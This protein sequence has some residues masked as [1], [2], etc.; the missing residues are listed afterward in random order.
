MSQYDFGTIDPY[1]VDGVQLADMLNQW[2]DALLSMHRGAARPTY[3]VPGMM[4]INDSAGAASW[5]VNVYLGPT[6]GDTPLFNYN[7]TTGAITISAASGGT[8]AAA[9]LLAQANANPTVEWNSTQ[10]PID[11]KDWRSIITS[12]GALRFSAYNDAGTTELGA[13]QIERDGSIPTL[14]P[15]GV[16]WDFGGATAPTGWYLCDGTL[17][18]RTTDA[19]LFTAISTTFGA[20]DGSTTFAVPDLRGRVA[21]GIDGGTGRLPGF[22]SMGAAGGESAH[23]LTVAE[24]PAHTHAF[25][26]DNFR[27]VGAGSYTG[28]VSAGNGPIYYADNTSN[29]SGGQQGGNALHN[30]VQATMALNKIIKR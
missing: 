17:K 16:I 20:G 25:S 30:N 14:I 23:T 4:W 27:G 18:S 19:R 9:K 26:A 15:P 13:L 22:T 3:V 12:T 6:T 8:F 29:F 21:A 2:R 28:P 7:T 24:M 1:V 10:N 5:V 11:Q